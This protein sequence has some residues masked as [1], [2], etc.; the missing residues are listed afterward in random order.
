MRFE[1]GPG[2]NAVEFWKIC[3]ATWVLACVHFAPLTHI[4][5]HPRAGLRKYSEALVLI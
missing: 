3:M 2:G 5:R 1:R 4:L